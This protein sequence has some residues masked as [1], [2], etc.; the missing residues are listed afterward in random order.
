MRNI[1]ILGIAA[2]LGLSTVVAAQQRVSADCRQEIVASCGMTR[3]RDVIRSCLQD[4]S[5]QLS[6]SCQSELKSRMEARRAERGADRRQPREG[7]AGRASVTEY[8]YGSDKLQALN[9]YPV[10]ATSNGTKAPL[11]IFVHGGGWS[12]GDKRSATGQYKAPHYNGQGYAFASVNYRLVPAAT[13]EQ[14]AQD[15]ASAISWLHKDA[16]RLGIDKSRIVLMGHSAGAHLAALVATDPQ[17]LKAAGL[18]MSALRGVIPLDG[19]AYDVAAQIAEGERIMQDNY[20]QAFGS[21]PARQAAL[22]PTL[23]AKTPGASPFLILH[24]DRDS[25]A[26]Q[27]SEL[28][29]TL[30]NAGTPAQL[31]SVEGK[32]MKGHMEINRE[33]GKADYPATAI[34]DAWLAEVFKGK[35]N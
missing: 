10:N 9:F 8:K 3:D 23:H 16:D 19:A 15:V 20:L 14:Q 32:G 13:V 27:S 18:P 33:L 35:T 22:S 12:K 21:D 6:D 1:L 30:N 28:A 26:K 5:A 7:R 29:R 24:V 17:Y 25:A 4:K 31:R 11:I 34:V 2:S